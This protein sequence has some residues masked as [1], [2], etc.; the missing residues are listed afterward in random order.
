M[1]AIDGTNELV[2]KTPTVLVNA[3]IERTGTESDVRANHIKSM[4]SNE[5]R[6]IRCSNIL[7]FGDKKPETAF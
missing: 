5:S 7:A 2:N 4:T 6:E 1:V 3:I